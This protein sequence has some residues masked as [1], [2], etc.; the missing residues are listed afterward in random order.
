MLLL[1]FVMP[2][3]LFA[4]GVKIEGKTINPETKEETGGYV[5]Y[6][7]ADKM[8]MEST[9]KGKKTTIIFDKAAGSFT[10]IDHSSK[11]YHELS[12]ADIDMI[13]QRMEE[14]E[15]QLEAAMANMTPEQKAQMEQM[16]MQQMN[17][18][19]KAKTVYKANGQSEVINGWEC[20]GYNGNREGMQHK[21]VFATKLST[22]G[23]TEADVAVMHDMSEA[24][25]NMT[26]KMSSAGGFWSPGK[27]GEEDR[28]EGV[29]IKIL[30]YDNGKVSSVST[31]TAVK[32][33]DVPASV[34]AIPTGFTKQENPF[35]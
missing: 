32:K 7:E 13:K 19:G 31:V 5:L 16:Q 30:R 14:M 26:G 8:V 3:A 1:A 12:Q 23:L 24:L 27:A 22:L 35:R 4:G 10:M 34:Y 11:S 25:T 17:M 6:V 33:M 21:D 2:L 29:P 20:T 15:K 9:E 18:Q 28:Y